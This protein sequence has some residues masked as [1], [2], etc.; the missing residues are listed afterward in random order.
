M[1][2]LGVVRMNVCILRKCIGKIRKYTRRLRSLYKNTPRQ[3]FH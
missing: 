1:M 3:F 2:M